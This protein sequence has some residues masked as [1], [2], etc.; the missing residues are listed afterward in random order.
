MLVKVH[1]HVFFERRLSVVDRNGVVVSIQAMNKCLNRRL[2]QM[3][4]VAG[5][6][7]RLLT[8]HQELRVDEAEGINDDLSLHRLNGVHDDSN[9]SR[10]KLLE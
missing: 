4:Q 10:V 7:T 1:Q 2:I 3:S 8:H 9:G 5:A 6:L